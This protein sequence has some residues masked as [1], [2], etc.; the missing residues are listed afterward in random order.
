MFIYFFLQTIC[1][2]G[3]MNDLY[4]MAFLRLQMARM[5]PYKALILY[6]NSI[7]HSES[8]FDQRVEKKNMLI[9]ITRWVGG[10]GGED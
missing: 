7:S 10:P 1:H 6:P 5:K 2:A 9:Y 8:Y 3:R 4:C